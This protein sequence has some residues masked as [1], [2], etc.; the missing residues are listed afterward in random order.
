MTL[1]DRTEI[2]KDLVIDP[3]QAEQFLRSRRSIRKFRAKPVER[4]KIEKLLQIA[5]YAPSAHNAQPVHFLV[6]ED[7]KEVKRIFLRGIFREHA[8][9]LEELP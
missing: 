4:E 8:S 2:R 3:F 1:V 6:I 9:S 7:T 5:G